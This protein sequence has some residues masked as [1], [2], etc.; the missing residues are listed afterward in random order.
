MTVQS[1]ADPGVDEGRGQPAAH[2]AYRAQAVAGWLTEGA[3]TAEAHQRARE[4]WGVSGRT[5]DRLIHAA[6]QLLRQ[7]WEVDRVEM[8]ALLLARLDRVYADAL[9]AGNHGAA[10]GAINSAAKLAQLL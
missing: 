4:A 5:A 2:N 8:L 6:R 7:A 3:S 9:R 1:L 10:L